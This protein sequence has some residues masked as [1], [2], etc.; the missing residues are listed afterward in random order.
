MEVWDRRITR[1]KQQ[2]QRVILMEPDLCFQVHWCN[3]PFLPFINWQS[4]DFESELDCQGNC[5]IN[6]NL[7]RKETH[8]G[9]LEQ[10]SS[11]VPQVLPLLGRKFLG[12]AFATVSEL[13]IPWLTLS[14]AELWPGPLF[15]R[16]S[17]PQV[18]RILS[19]H[20][21]AQTLVWRSEANMLELAL[22]HHMGRGD[23]TRVFKFGS[24]FLLL[25]E[26]PHCSLDLFLW[27]PNCSSPPSRHSV[28]GRRA[29][30]LNTVFGIGELE[31][32]S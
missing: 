11:A 27:P 1:L 8:S 20:V 14:P 2:W 18:P 32:S 10:L 15:F 30:G 23:W 7:K 3:L 28:R 19:L 29:D 6:W 24:R 5:P 17:N 31:A 25:T 21:H 13:S 22:F 12:L 16:S 26:P 9:V 4:A